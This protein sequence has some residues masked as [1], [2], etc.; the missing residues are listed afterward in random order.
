MFCCLQVPAH[1]SPW[2]G[3]RVGSLILRLLLPPRVLLE[4][5]LGGAG[6]WGLGL[7]NPG[8]I[9]RVRD[10]TSRSRALNPFWLRRVG[11]WERVAGGAPHVRAGHPQDPHLGVPWEPS[12]SGAA[13]TGEGGT[14]ASQVLYVC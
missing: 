1:F 8:G 14:G 2:W 12:S 9:C 7:C 13:L 4:R 3:A 11:A 10:A 6:V 5:G